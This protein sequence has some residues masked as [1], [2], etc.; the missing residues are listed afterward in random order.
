MLPESLIYLNNAATSWPKAPG[1]TEAV[2]QA[3]RQPP[4]AAN[5]G[6]IEDFDVMGALR[7]ELC[8]V[9]GVTDPSRI[10]LGANATWGLN[11]GIFGLG[12]TAGDC[13][14]TTKAEHNSV[15]RPLYA[16][17]QG[18][19]VKVHYLD[20]DRFGRV[21]VG[22][23]SAAIAKLQPQLCVCTHASNVTG[24][25]NDVAALAAA[26][27]AGGALL[28]L[29][30]A[31]S[32]GW[33]DVA[34]EEWGVDLAAFTGHKYLL[35]PQGIGGLYVRPGLD[36]I[37]H[38]VGGTGIHSDSELMP[39]EMPLHLEAGTGNEPGAYGLLAALSWL[40][41]N[42]LTADAHDAIEA[43]LQFL[44]AALSELGAIVIDPGPGGTPVLSFTFADMTPQDIGSLL[45]DS[46]D[47][48]VR[49][50]LH[51]APYI[52]SCLDVDPTEG[53]VRVSLSRFTI[54]AEILAFIE[55]MRD[56][57]TSSAGWS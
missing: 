39:P 28:L 43:E 55:A 36:L 37:P 23:W 46:Y 34:L 27:H 11:V 15:L 9:L 2:A 31:Q 20:T 29:D 4:G 54:H 24:A 49:T 33:L 13:V 41:E 44:K 38:L 12:L 42:P 51:C 48:V 45:C 22:T 7:K 19:G 47:I 35:G 32:L 3:L 21:P 14:L 18:A 50:G 1:V 30:V 25:V 6:G 56:I 40:R 26:A 5:R 8:C 53:T 16:L 52:F 10:A 57:I 17:S